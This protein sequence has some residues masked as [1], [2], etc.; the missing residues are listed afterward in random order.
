MIKNKISIEIIRE[1]RTYQL[2]L[3]PDSP[4]D[5]CFDVISEIRKY[6]LDR[7][8]ELEGSEK[9]TPVEEISQKEV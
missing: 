1:D 9:Q 8:N 7:I 6:I 5:E 2:M 4:L 3:S